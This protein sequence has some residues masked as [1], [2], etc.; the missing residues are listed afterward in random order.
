MHR[1]TALSRWVRRPRRRT[2]LPD[3]RDPEH[4]TDRIISGARPGRGA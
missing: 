2:W 4:A 3:T 1:T